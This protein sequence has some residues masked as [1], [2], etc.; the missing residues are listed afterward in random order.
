MQN[1]VR[2]ILTFA[3]ISIISEITLAIE[4]TTTL[5]ALAIISTWLISAWICYRKNIICMMTAFLSTPFSMAYNL[6]IVGPCKEDYTHIQ[7]HPCRLEYTDHHSNMDFE[8][9]DLL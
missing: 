7:N 9:K 3:S 5:N 1:I 8:H 2:E 6:R 4:A